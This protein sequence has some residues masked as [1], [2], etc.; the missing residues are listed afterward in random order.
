MSALLNYQHLTRQQ[1]CAEMQISESTVRRWELC[2]L[3]HMPE[4]HPPPVALRLFR[5]STR[6]P[7]PRLQASSQ[8]GAGQ[9]SALVDAHRLAGT[10]TDATAHAADSCRCAAQYGSGAHFR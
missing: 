10:V 3:P 6:R 2:G 4:S 9:R 1:L 5:S 8:G 7:R